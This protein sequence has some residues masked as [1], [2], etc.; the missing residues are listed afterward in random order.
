MGSD[1]ETQTGEEKDVKALARIMLKIPKAWAWARANVLVLGLLGWNGLQS[2][3][4]VVSNSSH[5]G[6]I[7]ASID[8]IFVLVKADHRLNIET[9]R[10]A[11]D[12]NGAFLKLK[13]GQAAMEAFRRDREEWLRKHKSDSI[14]QELYGTDAD[15]SP[16]RSYV[17]TRAARR[18]E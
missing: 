18:P 11:R 7:H 8:S 1:S 4:T 17:S 16:A 15:I 9:A 12:L 14:N 2:I 3:G 10:R 13:G 5:G 6:H